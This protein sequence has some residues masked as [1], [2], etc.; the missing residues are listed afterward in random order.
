M[1]LSKKSP[2]P[3]HLLRTAIQSKDL[4]AFRDAIQHIQP[5]AFVVS[6]WHE[7]LRMVLSQDFGGDPSNYL[8]RLLRHGEE[9]N[10]TG[11]RLLLNYE[12]ERIG[13]FEATDFDEEPARLAEEILIE[14][15]Q[16]YP[17]LAW[18]AAS[19]TGR[20]LFHTAAEKGSRIV[21]DILAEFMSGR[22]TP[23]RVQTTVRTRDTNGQTA[24]VIA[25]R[26]DHERVV[27]ALMDLDPEQFDESNPNSPADIESAVEGGQLHI[28]KALLQGRTRLVTPSLLYRA[29]SDTKY[30]ILKY[31]VELNPEILRD[32]KSNFLI[33]AVKRGHVRVIELLLK[34]F[35]EL[36]DQ[37]EF[38]NSQG[39]NTARKRYIV[40]TLRARSL[41]AKGRCLQ[42]GV[43]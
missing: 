36:T 17:D 2:S 27:E 8:T 16:L 14:M 32:P 12:I 24:L 25:V 4:E 31:L 43:N 42:R 23:E 22:L 26:G 1:A 33:A 21:I 28:L 6:S 10:D 38:E 40:R 7:C 20:T 18:T 9:R 41:F 3:I 39:T 11:R 13:E 19:D 35:P 37:F 5:G 34:T 30:D 29:L 15:L